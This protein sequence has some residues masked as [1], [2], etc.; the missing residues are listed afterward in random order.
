MQQCSLLKSL[1][2]LFVHLLF[3]F[4]YHQINYHTS[5]WFIV[6]FTHESAFSLIDFVILIKLL[7]FLF[8][9]HSINWYRAC[10][11][12]CVCTISVSTY[13]SL[14]SFSNF[15]Q[16]AVRDIL[17]SVGKLQLCRGIFHLLPLPKGSAEG[18]IGGSLQTHTSIRWCCSMFSAHMAWSVWLVKVTLT[19]FQWDY[20]SIIESSVFFT[21]CVFFSV[22]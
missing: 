12:A 6:V 11:C 4:R 9:N 10:V 3:Q 19:W 14:R 8:I 15:M 21:C 2:C 17:L 13:V 18:E 16:C 1:L 22:T 5:N 20:L 7:I